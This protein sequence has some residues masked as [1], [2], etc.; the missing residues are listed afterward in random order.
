M[1]DRDSMSDS[2]DSI[3]DEQLFDVLDRYMQLLHSDGIAARAD[4]IAAHPQLAE[5]LRCLDELESLA[6]MS[7][8]VSPQRGNR[9]P[10]MAPGDHAQHSDPIDMLT[11]LGGESMAPGSA[12]ETGRLGSFGRYELLEELGRGGM[13]VVYRARQSDL[14]RTVAV[15]M[16]LAS[17]FASADE[18]RRFY[19]E[20]R[21]AG[22]LQHPNIVGIHEV[23]EID[24][25]HY[26]AMDLVEGSSL[27]EVIHH[28][29]RSPDAAAETIAIVARA[30]A[31]LHE[32]GIV[33]RDLKPS[34]ILLD[35]EGR[36][37]VTD[38]GLAR[39]FADDGR[40]TQT[41]TIIGTPGYMSPEQAAGRTADVSPKSDVYSLGAIL[42]EMLTGRPPFQGETPLDT[43]VEV[44]EGEPTLPH[45]LN[46]HVPRELE[47]IC[48]RCLEKD[49][50]KRYLSATALAE[51]LEHFLKREPVSARPIGIVQRLRRW[52]RREPALISRLVGLLF[53]SAI[54]QGDY[55]WDGQDVVLFLRVM[56]VFGLWAAVCVVF[57]RL[58]HR[59]RWA[60]V[61]RFAWAA[62]DVVL[63]TIVLLLAPEPIG[64]LLIGYPLLIAAA[65]LFFRVRLVVFTT[66]VS[67]ASFVWLTVRRSEVSEQPH[68][69]LIFAAVLA[70]IGFVVAYQ[71]YR[72]RVLSRYYGRRL[73]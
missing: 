49:P 22:S 52:G 10:T 20:A 66:A 15:K 60:N 67:M 28:G 16:I 73:P 72:V 65:G 63:L 36:P 42:Y 2:A 6:P 1:T 45:V 68:Y 32:Q 69:S 53:A 21:A 31:Y 35:A 44:I 34:N 55:L 37:Y 64:P 11:P 3:P 25:Q 54:V 40:H 58:L 43:L 51:D 29:D 18:V 39:I 46:R 12:D 50:R 5:L 30:V 13:G 59:E 56:M 24:G 17:R 8:V 62:A 57:Q 41:G 33:H 14:D 9:D 23:G 38:F 26:F 27:T 19:A 4:L 71:V 47:L 61:A 70:V 7:N 48:L